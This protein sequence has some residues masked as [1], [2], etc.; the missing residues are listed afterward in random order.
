MRRT[1][2]QESAT[3]S[4]RAREQ[5]RR[6]LEILEAA[7]RVIA[8]HGFHGAGMAEIA[9][10]AEYAVGTLY[11]LFESKEALY[12]RLL[13]ERAKEFG[14]A[15]E[16]ALAGASRTPRERLEAALATKADFFARHLDFVR[17]YVSTSFV[18]TTAHGLPPPALAIRD[19]LIDVVA[20]VF[21]EAR[22]RGELR[23][24]ASATDLAVAFQALTQA[25]LIAAARDPDGFDPA[26]VR[27]SVNDV[28]LDPVFA[29]G[30][31]RP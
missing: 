10:E 22:E 21:A 13:L 20:G 30:G 16:S 4:R 18:A 27:A 1:S 31:G 12:E 7:E 24:E 2:V 6:E 14:A 25:F 9:R 28:L 17:I 5:K 8:L 15:M 11:N 29:A 19:R 26:R 3:A 23:T